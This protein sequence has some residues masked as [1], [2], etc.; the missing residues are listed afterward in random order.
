MTEVRMRPHYVI[1]RVG[2]FALLGSLV[3]CTDKIELDDCYPI[4]EL[5]QS[6]RADDGKI[7]G[8]GYADD[9]SREAIIVA[10][11]ANRGIN[12]PT[13]SVYVYVQGEVCGIFTGEW[14]SPPISFEEYM[15]NPVP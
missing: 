5:A 12:Y 8:T 7:V 13:V 2:I 6:I 9:V 11:P 4:H 10:Y 3:A 14:H 15:R 1:G